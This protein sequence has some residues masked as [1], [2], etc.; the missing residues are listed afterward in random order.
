MRAA[1]KG[2]V[3]TIRILLSSGADVNRRG[4]HGETALMLA[5]Q[6]G[7]EATVRLLL[8]APDRDHLQC[9]YM[10]DDD[11]GGG[12]SDGAAGHT[13]PRK[14]GHYEEE[15]VVDAAAGIS[16]MARAGFLPTQDV[17]RA[18]LPAPGG[19][20]EISPPGTVHSSGICSV[21]YTREL[22]G[23]IPFSGSRSGDGG[24][25]GGMCD[26]KHRGHQD[27]R[28]PFDSCSSESESDHN[29]CVDEDEDEDKDDDNVT[30]VEI[31]VKGRGLPRG[32]WTA[33]SVARESGHLTCATLVQ[34]AAAA[35][36]LV[37]ATPSLMGS[38]RGQSMVMAGDQHG[39]PR[40]DRQLH[41]SRKS[42][43]VRFSQSSTTQ[44][45][46]SMSVSPGTTRTAADGCVLLHSPLPSPE[47]RRKT[48]KQRVESKEQEEVT[49]ATVEA[50]RSERPPLFSFSSFSSNLLTGSFKKIVIGG[51]SGTLLKSPTKQVAPAPAQ[52]NFSRGEDTVL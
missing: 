50:V 35:T 9:A 37:P 32:K 10:A 16:I 23:E 39:K 25:G 47:R 43:R 11:S 14:D 12:D 45:P 52:P 22:G 24:D 2:V 48:T 17:S 42:Q 26:L 5:C 19:G 8:A 3:E 36:G 51:G 40:Q 38:S 41:R 13:K 21:T 7:D 15:G 6:R 29:E 30:A 49:G 20:A 44:V 27:K 31:L 33:A 18:T 34:E 4:R 46:S 1:Q 28:D